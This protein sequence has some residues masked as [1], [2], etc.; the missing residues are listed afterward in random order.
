MPTL[1]TK[2]AVL[3]MAPELARLSDLTI[4]QALLD[5]ALEV[6]AENL[7]EYGELAQ[8]LW[9]AHSLS[10]AN[11]TITPRQ[12][13]SVTMGG[14]SKTFTTSSTSTVDGNDLDATSYGRRLKGLLD[15]VLLRVGVT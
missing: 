2:E 15:S 5:V 14:M 9:V 10:V 13:S 1:T 4:Q 8:R 3:A 6:R 11:P 12:T 7:G